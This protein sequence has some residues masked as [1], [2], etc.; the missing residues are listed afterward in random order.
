MNLISNATWQLHSSLLSDHHA[1]EI[2]L[3]VANKPQPTQTNPRWLLQK[4]H[5][6]LFRSLLEDVQL[7]TNTD[8]NCLNEQA[9]TAILAAA[10]ESIP[11][12]KGCP[13]RKDQWYFNKMKLAKSLLN[14][15]VRDY[16]NNRSLLNK[17]QVNIHQ[18]YLFEAVKAAKLDSWIK[19]LASLHQ[20]PSTRDLWHRINIVQGLMPSPPTHPDPTS[21]ANEINCS[22]FERSASANSDPAS[23]GHQQKKFHYRWKHITKAINNKHA[24]YTPFTL[25]ELDRAL[26][27]KKDSAPGEDT[28]SCSMVKNSLESFKLQLLKIFQLLL[29]IAYSPH[30]METR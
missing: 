15:A 17:A 5:L 14:Q 3:G 7:N 2:N 30:I 25:S 22:F 9:S 20:Q 16:K 13:R 10:A 27:N 1:I 11:T 28:I 29:E 23:L 19:W 4:A 18:R 24:A 6:D 21:K 26:S 8:I 12:S